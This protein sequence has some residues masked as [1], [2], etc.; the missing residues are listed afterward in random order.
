M[1]LLSVC[2]FIVGV[3]QRLV[4]LITIGFL[5]RSANELFNTWGVIDQHFFCTNRFLNANGGASVPRP[6]RKYS[7]AARGI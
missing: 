2:R 1:S 7:V 5:E 3:L 6:T 4:V